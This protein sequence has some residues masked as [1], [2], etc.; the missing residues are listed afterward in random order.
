MVSI[1]VLGFGDVVGG[2]EDLSDLGMDF[3]LRVFQPNY[4]KQR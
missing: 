2:L 4:F 1:G 3:R